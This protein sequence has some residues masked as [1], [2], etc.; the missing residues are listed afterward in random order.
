MKCFSIKNHSAISHSFCSK[1]D[2]ELISWSS[3]LRYWS[4]IKGNLFCFNKISLYYVLIN[5]SSCKL[6]Y[7][8]TDILFKEGIVSIQKRE[9]MMFLFICL[10]VL[11][12]QHPKSSYYSWVIVQLTLCT[13]FLWNMH[14]YIVC[15]YT[16]IYKIIILISFYP[17][18]LMCFPEKQQDIKAV[19]LAWSLSNIW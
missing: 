13:K 17:F 11:H 2:I 9:Q 1:V 3:K 12:L 5:E 16:Y 8:L 18:V 14:M 10:M 7:W 4:L 6:N 19:L 15:I